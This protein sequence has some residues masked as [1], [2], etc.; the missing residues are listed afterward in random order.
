MP[1]AVRRKPPPVYNATIDDDHSSSLP[2][3]HSF[4]LPVSLPL[5]TPPPITPDSD[6]H[7]HYSRRRTQSSASPSLPTS[8]STRTRLARLLHSAPSPSP[9]KPTISGPTPVNFPPDLL[10]VELARYKAAT[11]PM[12]L[13]DLPIIPTP[14]SPVSTQFSYSTNSQSSGETDLTTPPTSPGEDAPSFTTLFLRKQFMGRSR[15]VD[16]HSVSLSGARSSGKLSASPS[17]Y[18]SAS[19]DGHSS[20]RKPPSVLRKSPSSNRSLNSKRSGP[21]L[22]LTPPTQNAIERAVRLPLVS[23]NGVRVQFGQLLGMSRESLDL[24][25]VGVGPRPGTELRRTVV[26]F[27]RHFWCPLCQDYMVALA[28]G[29]RA[30]TC[31]KYSAN[32]PA[33]NLLERLIESTKQVGDNETHLLVIA[34]GSHTLAGKYLDSFQFSGS[35]GI[36]SV[37]IF[38]DPMPAEGVYAAL[39]MGWDGAPPLAASLDSSSSSTCC[40]HDTL[41]NSVGHG[42]SIDPEAAPETYITHGSFSGIGS[43]L[44]RAIRSGLP[45]W[46]KGGD[47][48]LL[49]GEF[50]FELSANGSIRCVYAHRMQHP[51]GHASVERVL[52]AAGVHVPSPEPA[53]KSP[54]SM[55]SRSASTTV[56]PQST[57]AST[58]TAP[59]I[60]R[61]ASVAGAFPSRIPTSQ[62]SL[63]ASESTQSAFWR[64]GSGNGFFHRFAGPRGGRL[65]ASKL[66]QSDSKPVFPPAQRP[67]IPISASTPVNMGYL[68]RHGG[69][70]ITERQVWVFGW[71]LDNIV[72]LRW[73]WRFVRVI[74]LVCLVWF[75]GESVSLY[76]FVWAYVA[77]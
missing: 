13:V 34:P 9:R 29:V 72:I 11:R 3:R 54:L 25:V 67:A 23:P 66:S 75:G 37:R 50:V 42:D 31:N 28:G 4:A 7:S 52:A 17:E 19:L 48:R 56:I 68:G 26:I 53:K 59:I 1:S 47:I 15:S 33:E 32:C 8:S 5:S 41:E 40:G 64:A 6:I 76:E 22:P 20:P 57:S 14:A 2:T 46:A 74:R 51:R 21:L 63:V 60:P 35:C 39:G 58:I 10:P 70:S 43:V 65:P 73:C 27:L 45:V 55:M 71:A 38:V 61:S 44:M 16:G 77:G 18:T 12:V 30:A 69:T 49:G 62:S 24:G 36:A